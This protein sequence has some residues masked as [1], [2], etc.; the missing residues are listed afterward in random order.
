MARA[1][2]RATRS[3]SPARKSLHSQ[4]DATW[5]LFNTEVDTG[6]IGL[7]RSIKNVLY[8]IMTWL[9]FYPRTSIYPMVY[10]VGM[11]KRS[12]VDLDRKTLREPFFSQC[13]LAGLFSII[14]SAAGIMMR[15]P[16]R[17][18]QFGGLGVLLV[19]RC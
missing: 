17:E 12:V 8:E 15:L 7:I 10:A 6:F 3:G 9:V 4:P 18:W 13:Y 2:G 5:I 11:V 19:E 14:V 1:R 16:H